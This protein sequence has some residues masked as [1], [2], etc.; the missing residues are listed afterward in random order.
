MVGRDSASDY[1]P[2]AV[3]VTS[4]GGT[5]VELDSETILKLGPDLILAAEITPIE[6]VAEL[7]GHEL[8]VF[9]L[10]NPLELEGLY[11]NLSLVGQL[12]GREEEADVLIEELEARVAAVDAALADLPDEERPTVFYELDG[13]DP[14]AIWTAGRGTFVSELIRRAGGIN[15]GEILD[16][17]FGQLSVEELIIQD[18][19][20]ILLGDAKFIDIET[21]PDRAGWSGLTAIQENQY[22]PFDPDLL[23]RPGP[24]LVD[25]LEE[26]ARLLHPELFE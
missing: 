11:T 13:S 8:T 25:A 19:D 18:P 22:Y 9:W 1:P 2:A 20:I 14:S 10:A 5:F 21:V 17:E 6:Y 7:E 24:R 12:V 23:S 26:L 16:G 4:V 15:I 3:S